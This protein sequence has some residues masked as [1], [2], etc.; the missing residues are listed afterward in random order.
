MTPEQESEVRRLDATGATTRAIAEAVGVS[1][2]TVGRY[3]R[4]HRPAAAPEPASP[5]PDAEF[6]AGLLGGAP[7][8]V[9]A[10][11]G[12]EPEPT[13]EDLLTFMRRS[14]YAAQSDARTARTAGNYAVAQKSS[15]DAV[16][17]AAIVARLE[18]L[19]TQRE[20]MLCVKSIAEIDAA[21]ASLDER[22][23]KVEDQPLCC[24]E[25]GRAMRRRRAEE[26]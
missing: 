7:A 8:P 1:H 16:Q 6:L 22:A 9:V 18:K 10:E 25:C 17:Y 20:G 15:R 14:M 24:S 21:M 5:T 4:A 3:L 13:N 26:R 12:A 11:P 19:E 2:M 23:E